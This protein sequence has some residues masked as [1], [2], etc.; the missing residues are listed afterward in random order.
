MFICFSEICLFYIT[1][2]KIEIHI[3][4]SRYDKLITKLIIYFNQPFIHTCYYTKQ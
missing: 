2:Y 4:D 3:H 1:H